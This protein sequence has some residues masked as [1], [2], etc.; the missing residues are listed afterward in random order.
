MVRSVLRRPLLGAGARP[1]K[2]TRL[3]YDQSTPCRGA[4]NS[5][6]EQVISGM[7]TNPRYID[8]ITDTVTG[9]QFPELWA[10]H[11]FETIVALHAANAPINPVSVGDRLELDG[12]LQ[13]VGGRARLHELAT[14]YTTGSSAVWHAERVRDAALLRHVGAIGANLQTLAET[15]TPDPDSVLDAINT[16]RGTLDALVT[17]DS[18]DT[19]LEQAVYDALASLEEPPGIPTP[20]PSYTKVIAGWKPSSIYV[21]GARPGVGK[22]LFAQA[23]A[24]DCARRGQ[25][26]MI[27]SLE[28]SRN[29]LLL[30]MASAVGE[31]D[32]GRIQHRTLTPTDYQRL[33]AAAGNIS[34]LPLI[35]DERADISVA[36][37]RAKVRAT[38]RRTKVG[39]VIVDYLGLVRPPRNTPGNDRRVQV[40]AVSRGFK[41][42]AKELHVPVVVLSQLNRG[43]E[44]RA[45]KE[46][47]MSD[48]R[49]SGSIE[50]DADV[51]TLLHRDPTGPDMGSTIQFLTGKNRH[52]PLAKTELNFRGHLSRIEDYQNP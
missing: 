46:P 27:F 5:H 51:V 33:S 44:Q 10:E 41:I 24:L 19:T 31:V 52:G 15:T 36:Q 25:T 32:A 39:I 6:T 17:N 11:V 23:V 3:C 7:L 16:A 18:T 35:I 38:Q 14:N 12:A 22:S 40:D 34:R 8:D 47:V 29:E 37:I 2:H 45:T 30:R 49:E 13:R 50:Q 21:I 4:M 42:L 28:M 1:T 48:L 20:W 9:P 43:P 26:A